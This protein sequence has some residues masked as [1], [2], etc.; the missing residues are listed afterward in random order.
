MSGLSF[1]F[2]LSCS[3]FCDQV[4]VLA[5]KLAELMEFLRNREAESDQLQCEIQDTFKELNKL[6]TPLRPKHTHVQHTK[7]LK[8]LGLH[9][10]DYNIT[11][12]Y[13]NT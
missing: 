7:E 1:Q 12:K 2:F 13:T 11:H 4:K 6:E 5:L 9:S 8:D 3:L 10:R